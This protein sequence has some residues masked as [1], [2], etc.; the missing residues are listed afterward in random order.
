MKHAIAI[1]ILL[2]LMVGCAPA[3]NNAASPPK[4]PV[5]GVNQGSQAQPVVTDNAAQARISSLESDL[6]NCQALNAKLYKQIDQSAAAT[7]VPS[8]K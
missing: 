2:I 7:I 5:A 3:G 1:L 8:N 4:A 6:A